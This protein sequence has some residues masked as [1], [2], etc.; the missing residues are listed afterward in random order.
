MPAS[1]PRFCKATLEGIVVQ[2]IGAACAT[3]GNCTDPASLIFNNSLMTTPPAPRQAAPLDAVAGKIACIEGEEPAHAMDVH[4]LDQ[5]RVMH[6][7][8]DYAV[9]RNQFFPLGVEWGCI[10]KKLQVL[11][12][13]ASASTTAGEKPSP[14]CAAGRV[15]TFQGNSVAGMRPLNPPQQHIRVDEN[16]HP[17]S[18]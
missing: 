12:D 1:P 6:F 16:A 10:W 2:P 9:T 3:I 17:R 5:P 4:R 11:L 15:A 18:A 7:D 13:V 14:L 8:V